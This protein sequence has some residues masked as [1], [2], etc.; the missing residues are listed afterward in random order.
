MQSK[1]KIGDVFSC[2]DGTLVTFLGKID[3]SFGQFKCL[4]TQKVF[5]VNM[6]NVF[7]GKAKNPFPTQQG[8][9]DSWGKGSSVLK[10]A[11]I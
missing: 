1:Y 7:K 9:T 10:I 3:K 8:H 4:A 11:V 6:W 2:S 5:V